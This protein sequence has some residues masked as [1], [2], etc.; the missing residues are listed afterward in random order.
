MSHGITTTDHMFSVRTMPWHGLGVVLDE[1][2]RSIDEALHSA[3]LDGRSPTVT[4]SSSRR[5]SGPTTSG[6]PIRPS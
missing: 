1:Y 3:G 6:P 2:P 4:S 5:R